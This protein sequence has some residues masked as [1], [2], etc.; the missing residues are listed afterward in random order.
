MSAEHFL[1]TN[2]FIYQIEA[3]DEVKAP[4]AEKIIREGV[5]TG[6]ACIS[7]PVI[8]EC[9]S[10]ITR[11][12][13]SP[14]GAADSQGYLDAILS[15]LLVVGASI[16]LYSK[17]IDIQSRYRFS[18][19]DALIVAAALE[20]GCTRLLTEDLQHGQR[21]GDLVIENPFLAG[22]SEGLAPSQT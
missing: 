4:I 3:R 10:T 19:Y 2:L 21:I 5:T 17:A 20:A 12:A 6:N 13:I 1:D 18:F 16:G 7:F 15:P 11:K 22:P 14:L 8:Q 9:L